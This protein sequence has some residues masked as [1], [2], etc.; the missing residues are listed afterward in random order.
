MQKPQCTQV[1]EDPVRPRGG[2]IG[3]LLGLKFV[4]IWASGR[5]G[6][7]DQEPAAKVGRVGLEHARPI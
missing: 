3:E 1:L 5:T 6:V 7:D 4:C 2:G